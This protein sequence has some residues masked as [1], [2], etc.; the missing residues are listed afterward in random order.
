MKKILLFAIIISLLIPILTLAEK[1]YQEDEIL[2]SI[3]NDLGG[4]LEEGET[5]ING[6]LLKEFLE[7][8]R[9]NSLVNKLLSKLEIQELDREE[10]YG[11]AYSQINLYSYDSYKNPI[12]MII[13][14]YSDEASGM[15]ETYL[16]LNLINKEHFLTNNDI[17]V[18]IENIFKEYNSFMEMTTS[19]LGYIDGNVWNTGIERKALKALRKYKG[20]TV[21]SFRDIN[22]LSYTAYTPYIVNNIT[23]DKKKININL[24]I[25]YNDYEDRTFIW[26]GTPIIT[27]G[28]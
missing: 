26:I 25:R 14:S 3:L 1:G 22:L 6:V 12:T 8:D 7:K 17:I 16:Y 20:E 21:E 24:A 13:S 9:L 2:L 27:S 5:S 11:E 28:Y 10:I 19:M 4:E 18:M 23:I 15:N